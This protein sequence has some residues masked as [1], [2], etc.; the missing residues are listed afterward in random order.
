MA[1]FFLL[2][3]GGG[4]F[5]FGSVKFFRIMRVRAYQETPIVIDHAELVSYERKEV[6]VAINYYEPK[7]KYRYFVCGKEYSGSMVFP[8][9]KYIMFPNEVEAR[10]SLSNLQER[11]SAFY[12]RKNPNCAL[13]YKPGRSEII[14]KEGGLPVAG[15]FLVL[16]SCCLMMF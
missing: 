12:N 1:T 7:V 2:F 4:V 13:L 10:Q 3:I 9:R 16:L 15:I 8:Y 5:T 11:K 6:Y 14:L